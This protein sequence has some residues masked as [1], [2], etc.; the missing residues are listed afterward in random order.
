MFESQLKS[1]ISVVIPVYNSAQILPEL[2]ERIA[3]VLPGLSGKFEV[4]LVNDGSRDESWRI[5]ENLAGKY[6]WLRGLCLMRN[7]GQHNALLAGVRAASFDVT[8]TMDDD[9]QQLPEE[10]LKL[11]SALDHGFDLVYGKRSKLVHGHVRDGVASMVKIAM[12][13][14]LGLKSA[15]MISPFRAFRTECRN[16]FEGFES[17][18]LSIDVLLSWSTQKISFVDV[19]HSKRFSGK[20]GYNFF[21]LANYAIDVIVGFSSWPLRIAS[22]VGFLFSFFGLL[23]LVYTLIC[24]FLFGATVSGF[25]FL[26]SII[27]IFAGFQLASLGV[28][29]EYL[30]TMHFRLMDKPTYSIM[31]STKQ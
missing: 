3:A 15:K 8:V 20:S 23:S 27:S 25:P 12:V 24:F 26:A 16:A 1:G 11:V 5:I 19:Q 6:E 29:G 2:V 22:I 17:P 4:L 30:A 21:R 7:Y 31:K 10:I 14:V 28:I 18:F 13:A 9:L